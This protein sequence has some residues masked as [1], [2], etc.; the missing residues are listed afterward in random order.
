MLMPVMYFLYNQCDVSPKPVNGD[1]NGKGM[2]VYNLPPGCHEV[3]M[4]MAVFQRID[5]A[6]KA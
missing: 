2:L 5:S 6:L 1:L 4:Y 3:G